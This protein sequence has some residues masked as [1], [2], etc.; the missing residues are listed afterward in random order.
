M[1]CAFEGI[2]LSLPASPLPLLFTSF[3]VPQMVRERSFPLL[4]F[5]IMPHSVKTMKL[6][7]YGLKSLK[8]Q[9]KIIFPLSRCSLG[10]CVMY[11]CMY[12]SIYV[13]ILSQQQ[14]VHQYILFIYLLCSTKSLL[15]NKHKSVD[16]CHTVYSKHWIRYCVFPQP[17]SGS[18]DI[19][20][21]QKQTRQKSS[22]G[23]Y[24][25]AA[26]FL[27]TLVRWHKVK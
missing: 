24:L 27:D 10:V 4:C 2:S 22:S 23:D 7:H 6:A 20:K 5:F 21:Y 9:S 15:V 17:Y 14:K 25:L 12:V 11:V 18:Q 19:I 13:F 26:A 16:M 3:S 8:L 1:G